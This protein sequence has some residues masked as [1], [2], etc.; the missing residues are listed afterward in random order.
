MTRVHALVHS[1][2]SDRLSTVSEVKMS[3]LHESYAIW[4]HSCWSSLSAIELRLLFRLSLEASAHLGVTTLESVDIR[5][6]FI[7]QVGVL[8]SVSLVLVVEELT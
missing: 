3:V 5:H 8:L 1:I 4:V 6:K 2:V 7:L